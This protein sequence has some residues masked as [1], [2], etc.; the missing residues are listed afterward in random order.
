MARLAA[1]GDIT[2]DG[3]LQRDAS[4]AKTFGP[5]I[6]VPIP[7]F[8]TGAPAR[9]HAEAEYLRASHTLN[10]L[11]AES[12]SQLRAARASVA[13]ARARVEYY[14][15]VIVPRRQRIVELTKLEHNPMVPGVLQPLHPKHTPATPPRYLSY[16]HPHHP[17]APTHTD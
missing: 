5:G 15:D 10:A 8:N 17:P 4:G 12:S 16:P 11:L 2:V 1:L 14:R 9:S 13:E 6:E 3:H 7:I